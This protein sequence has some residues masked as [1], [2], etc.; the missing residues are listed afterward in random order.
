MRFESV[1][2]INPFGIG[3][4]LFSTCLIRNLIKFYHGIKI[5]Y[6]CNPKVNSF[7]AKQPYIYKTFVY[8]RNEWVSLQRRSVIL[9]W[10]KFYNFIKEIK[11]EKIELC[12]DLS[13]NTQYGFYAW[14]AGI[15]FR[16]GLDY[17]KRGFFLQK[18][19]PI[20]GYE[21]KHVCEYHLDVLQLIGHIPK[22]YQMM[23]EVSEEQRKWADNFLENNVDPR[24]SLIVGVAPCGGDAFGKDAKVKRWP[25]ENFKEIIQ[26]LHE[27]LNAYV[28][29]FA[30]PNEKE[31]VEYILN[32]I[33]NKEKIFNLC[34]LSLEKTIALIERV[35]IFIGNDTGP[36]RIANAFR[37]K[38]L[39]FFGPVDEKVYGIYPPYPQQSI[40]LTAA[41]ACRPCYK[42]L[43]LPECNNQRR[44]LYD[45]TVA[46]AKEA[47]YKLLMV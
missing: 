34:Y 33:K 11:K 18:K 31:D 19:I 35:E 42:R 5:Y 28:F 22:E 39:A 16:I 2:I 17:K 12:I 6:L 24:D 7:L 10:K 25:A 32:P 43:R 37:K 27:E 3:D 26:W 9:W 44:C 38:I 4:V 47:V 1:L 13:L 8:D 46:E 45:I 21:Q 29:V 40:I 14:C 20:D 30:G 23:L 15:P 36:L 41:V